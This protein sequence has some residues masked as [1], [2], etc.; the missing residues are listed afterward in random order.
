MQY[1]ESHGAV[2]RAIFL[3]AEEGAYSMPAMSSMVLTLQ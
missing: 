3:C 2:G 1:K